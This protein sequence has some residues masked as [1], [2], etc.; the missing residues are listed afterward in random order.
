[1][2]VEFNKPILK[3]ICKFKVSRGLRLPGHEART[4]RCRSVH[5]AA[6]G[7]RLG[8]QSRTWS[9]AAGV[10]ARGLGLG[11]SWCWPDAGPCERHTR[12]DPDTTSRCVAGLAC[13]AQAIAPPTLGRHHLGTGRAARVTQAPA[14]SDHKG[15]DGKLD[16][17]Q[18]R[19]SFFLEVTRRLAASQSKESTVT[20]GGAAP[21]LVPPVVTEVLC[22]H[23][24]PRVQARAAWSSSAL[25][26]WLV[27]RDEVRGSLPT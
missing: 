21:G 25:E 10:T 22:A 24:V 18:F 20:A 26:I 15:K 5:D 6:R 4:S 8:W 13:E 9:P 2:Y 1:M 23:G 14:S 19:S 16:H 17:A 11:R 7:R 3:F 27:V 12:W